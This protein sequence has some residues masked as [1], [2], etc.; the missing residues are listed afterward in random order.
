MKQFVP[1]SP[2]PGKLGIELLALGDDRAELWLPFDPANATMGEVVHGGAIA[3]LIDTAGMAAA[4]AD[5]AVPEALGGAT[6][7]LNVD[8]LAAAIGT[9]LRAAA[10][11]RRRGRR[12]CF[13][14]V[15]VRAG[16]DR[17]IATGSMVHSYG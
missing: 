15:E 4:W 3:T 12:L 13:V 14:S 8:Y 11:V 17:L 7:T 9:D 16:D 2:L 6:V 5:D 1:N 10:T